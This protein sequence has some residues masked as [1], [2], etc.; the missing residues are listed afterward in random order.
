MLP[1]DT[2]FRENFKKLNI[3][4]GLSGILMVPVYLAS[5]LLFGIVFAVCCV[6]ALKPIIAMIIAL[7]IVVPL[8]F[9]AVWK[10]NVDVA[11]KFPYSGR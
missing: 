3:R 7:V 8:M 6:L 11:K 10:V 5:M 1:N 4:L 9:V 2:N